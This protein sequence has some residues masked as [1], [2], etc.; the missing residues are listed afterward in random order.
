MEKYCQNPLCENEAVKEVPVSIRKPSDQ[1]RSLCGAC[2]EV[3]SWGVQQGKMSCYRS[4]LWVLA[5]AD[6]GMVVHGQTYGSRR[7]AVE[8]L[9]EYLKSNENY[10]GPAEM[11]AISDW[12]AEHDERLSVELFRASMDARDS[13]QSDE[14]LAIEPPPQEQG[15]QEPLYRVVY[16]IDVH[17]ADVRDAAEYTH[18]IMA[19]PGSMAPVLHVLNSE[20]HDVVIDLSQE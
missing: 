13:G 14:G 5:I 8:G 4:R 7:R 15:S 20:G 16:I 12:L 11:P 6:R 18:R 1:K 10:A 2:E 3:Y 9:A 19:D 17:A